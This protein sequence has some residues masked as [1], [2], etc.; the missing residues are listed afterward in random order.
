M[1][2]ENG[3]TTAIPASLDPLW[4]IEPLKDSN[5]NTPPV[6][7][8]AEGGPP[9]Q[10]P[11]PLGAAINATA[12]NPLRL[13]VWVTDDAKLIPGMPKP[14]TPPVTVAWSKF[15]GPGAVTF[16]NPQPPV[17]EASHQATTTATFNQPGDYVLL[18]VANDWSGKGGRGF[19]CCWT[20]GHV[21]VS[22]KPR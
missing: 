4:E 7:K 16:D 10:G 21:K 8:L 15:R 12:G 3:Q 9:G 5:G 6:L 14:T 1:L 13:A 2:I 22:V 11:R 20:N 18:V 17:D 19:Q